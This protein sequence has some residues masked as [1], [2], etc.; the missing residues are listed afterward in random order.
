MSRTVRP[1]NE[2]SVGIPRTMYFRYFSGG[3]IMVLTFKDFYVEE[4][5]LMRNNKEVGWLENTGYRRFKLKG[6]KYLS[7]VVIYFLTTGDYPVYPEFLIDHKDR[8]RVNNCPT[9]LRKVS[10]SVNSSNATV[11]KDSS[12]GVKGVSERNGKY[13]VNICVNKKLITLG[14]HD[15]LESA[16]KLR[17]EAENAKNINF[18]DWYKQFRKDF[19]DK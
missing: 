1:Q 2:S 13:R 19:L 12:T 4:G 3:W 8:N 9:N 5:K 10:A 17:L 6:K 7:H 14:T 16:T 18:D 11:R 15:T